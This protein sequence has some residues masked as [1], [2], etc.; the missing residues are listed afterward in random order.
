MLRFASI[1]DAILERTYYEIFNIV[2][3]VKTLDQLY[4][5]RFQL[6]TH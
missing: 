4:L 6:L 2:T 3:Y 5:E 1:N